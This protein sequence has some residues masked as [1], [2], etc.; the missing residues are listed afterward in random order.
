MPDIALCRDDKCPR[1]E[2]C[3]R[4]TAKPS[5]WQSYFKGKPRDDYETCEYFMPIDKKDKT[6]SRKGGDEEK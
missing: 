5:Y 2:L 6:G 3:Y 1:R 4:Y